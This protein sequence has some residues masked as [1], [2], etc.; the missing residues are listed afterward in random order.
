M[1][2][3][4]LLIFFALWFAF[5]VALESTIVAFGFRSFFVTALM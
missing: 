4:Q 5:A 3:K 1:R 2:T